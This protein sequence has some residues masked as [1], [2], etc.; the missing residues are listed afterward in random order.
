MANQIAVNLAAQGEAEA[1]AQTAEHIARFWEP[2]MKAGIFAADQAQLVPIA[3][4][5]IARLMEEGRA[6]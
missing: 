2:R 3:R 4:A 1:I 6:A 5:A